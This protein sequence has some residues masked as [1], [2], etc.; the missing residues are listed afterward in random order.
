MTSLEALLV[1]GVVLDAFRLPPERKTSSRIVP[2]PQSP[3]YMAYFT[4]ASHL[5]H[6]RYY[7]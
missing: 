4:S 2:T 3:P 5:L 1:A 6:D 7:V